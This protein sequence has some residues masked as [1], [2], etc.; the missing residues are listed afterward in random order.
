MPPPLVEAEDLE[1]IERALVEVG[2]C[3]VPDV[4]GTDELAVVGGALD[5]EAAEDDATGTAL[6]YGPGASNQRLWALLNRGDEFVPLAA[7]PLALAVVRARMGADVL[8]SN[9]S[10]NI[11][12]PGGDHEI[13]RLHTDQGFLPEPWPYLLAT[14]VMWFLDDFTERNGATVVVPGSHRTTTVP[15]ADLA[16]AAPACLAGAAGSMAVLDGRLHHATGLNRTRDQKR[17]GVLATYCLPFLRTQEN[18]SRSLDP[19]LLERYPELA[20]LTGFE[21]WQTLGAVNGPEQSGLNF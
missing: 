5:R 7:H 10:A 8:L 19:D 13:G 9:L 20:A 2:Y 4:L 21:E 14:N 18:W 12:G 16:P 11:T 6:R 1:S 3:I 15:P 17:R